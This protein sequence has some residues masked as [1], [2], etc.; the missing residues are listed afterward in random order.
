MRHT[1]KAGRRALLGVA[2]VS[3]FCSGC[4][5]AEKVKLH[6]GLTADEARCLGELFHQRYVGDVSAS[7]LNSF[8]AETVVGKAD[9]RGDGRYQLI[10]LVHD[11]GYCGSAGCLMLIGE[12]RRDRK[13]HLIDE[14]DGGSD[15]VIVLDRRDHGYRRLYAPCE[16][17][18][19]GRQYQ[20]VREECPTIDVQR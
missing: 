10:F 15:T 17:Y 5:A 20:Q 3:L 11:I 19:D 16:L 2:C 14:G 12:R 9:L 18:F 6:K 8:V 13:C 4:L 7:E 1:N